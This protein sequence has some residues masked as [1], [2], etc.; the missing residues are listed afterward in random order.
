MKQPI[1][2]WDEQTGTASCIVEGYNTVF[3]GTAVCHPDDA[4]MCSMKT[5]CE[6]AYRRA[7]IK[8]LRYYR[9]C[10][11]KPALA[12]LKQLYYSMNRSKRFNPKSYE[13]NMLQRQICQKEM[14]LD[15][16]REMLT[17]KE[18]SL[19]QLIADKEEFYQHIRRHRKA[20]IK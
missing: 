7:E 12:A 5:G 11:L 20:N 6:I 1:F 17:G 16:V 8:A 18:Q 3:V 9:D 19:K 2:N 15:T 14:D 13:N 4:D 10:E